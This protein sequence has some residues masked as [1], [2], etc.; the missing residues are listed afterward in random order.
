MQ[1][2]IGGLFYSPGPKSLYEGVRLC[3]CGPN[4]RDS[5]AVCRHLT[6]Q[7]VAKYR[8]LQCCINTGSNSIFCLFG[9]S[10][11]IWNGNID[12]FRL[13]ELWLAILLLSRRT[14]SDF[15][16]TTVA[17]YFASLGSI[18]SQRHGVFLLPLSPQDLDYDYNGQIVVIDCLNR[19]AITITS[20]GSTSGIFDFSIAN[21]SDAEEMLPAHIFLVH[22]F[23]VAPCQ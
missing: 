12:G 6:N 4:S 14:R 9:A 23:V 19:T 15:G 3:S 16:L 18:V 2:A 22:L 11:I 8:F 5:S 7:L 13:P 20:N 1:N 10:P 21:D 17:Y